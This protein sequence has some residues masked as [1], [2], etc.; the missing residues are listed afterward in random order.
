VFAVEFMNPLAL[1]G[2]WVAVA[3]AVGGSVALPADGGAALLVFIV[4]VVVVPHGA[5]DALSLRSV[6]HWAAYIVVAVIVGLGWWFFPVASW[7]F[8][9]V[10]TVLHFAQG[11]LEFLPAG[12]FRRARALARGCLPVCL[13]GLFYPNEYAAAMGLVLESLNSDPAVA[14]QWGGFLAWWASLLTLCIWFACFLRSQWKW[15]MTEMLA[16][17]LVF[18]LAPPLL[19]IGLYLSFWHGWRHF[20]RVAALRSGVGDYSAVLAAIRASWVTI[21]V[22]VVGFLVVISVVWS[23]GVTLAYALGPTIAL[24]ASLTVPH[25]VVVTALDFRWLDA[26]KGTRALN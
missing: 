17:L 23:S 11:E 14:V 6:K 7:V 20:L 22:S 24:L 15:E 4:A 19:S 10:I 18:L 8:F 13:P 1:L 26:G 2:S 12:E 9:L 25:I 21:S 16:M 3:L 5:L